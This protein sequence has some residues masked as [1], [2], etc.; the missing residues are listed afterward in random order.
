[1]KKSKQASS[2]FTFAQLPHNRKEVFFDCLKLRFGTVV[3]CGLLLLLFLLPLIAIEI[4]YDIV[5]LN[6]YN[7]LIGG[8]MSEMQATL[9]KN[10]LQLYTSLAQTVCLGIFAVGLAGVALI[11]RQ[12]V[13]GEPIFFW[14]DFKRGIRQNAARFV[15]VF[16][17]CALANVASVLCS[18]M[19]DEMPIVGYIPLGALIFAVVPIALFVLSQSAVYNVGF[20]K[21]IS[22]GL[23]FYG[24]R[25]WQTLLFTALAL[26]VGLSRL[27]PI[28]ALK[29]LLM[30]L[31]TVFLLPMY[32]M[33]WLLVSCNVFDEVLNRDNYP[34]LFD[35]GVYRLD[36]Q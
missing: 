16:A 36:K 32:I 9:Y 12:L 13:W 25:L 22:N 31:C 30:L 28:S 4:T 10:E 3:C 11:L 29:Y 21:A 18:T 15:S 27:A 23:A 8:Q 2:D 33:A 19:L 7:S 6:I 24:K 26:I 17:I 20:G 1:M 35:K 34:E 5:N 14:V